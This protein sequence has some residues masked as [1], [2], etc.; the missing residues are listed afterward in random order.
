MCGFLNDDT[1]QNPK[2]RI[3]IH[4]ALHWCDFSLCRTLHDVH[5]HSAR[6]FSLCVRV[7][8]WDAYRVVAIV[9][10]RNVVE[11]CTAVAVCECQEDIH[12]CGTASVRKWYIWQ[13]LEFSELP[14]RE[15]KQCLV[16]GFYGCGTSACGARKRVSNGTWTSLG[17]FASSR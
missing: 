13:R 1:C 9:R 17:F 14:E 7:C 10:R 3:K 16:Y 4:G 12:P 8:I 2:S 15:K 11:W 5:T 6:N